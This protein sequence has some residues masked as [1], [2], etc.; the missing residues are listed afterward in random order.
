MYQFRLSGFADEAGKTAEEQMDVLEKNGVRQIEVRSIDG[1]NIL[2]LDENDLKRLAE[3]LDRRGFSVSAIGSP[4]GKSPIEEDFSLAKAAFEKALKAAEILKAPYIR[5]F[6]FFIPKDSEPMQWAAEVVS[7]LSELVKA[8][9]QRGLVYALENESGI[10]TDIP[11][12]CVHVLDRVPGLSLVFD[13]GNF[14]MNNASPLEAWPLLKNRTAYFHI[15][16]GTRN[17][18]HFVP[19]GEGEGNIAEI[20]KDAFSGGFNGNLSLEPHLKYL[21]GLSDA[22]RFT[23]AANALKRLLNDL[24]DA[25]LEELAIEAVPK[26]A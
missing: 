22:Q 13:P 16:D 25:G 12:R 8:A 19:A 23:T 5:G 21:E 7:R 18:R 15:K 14:I 20:L 3:K 9:G 4:V 6:S 10:F 1:K 17:P 26:L 2:E 24:F 11:E